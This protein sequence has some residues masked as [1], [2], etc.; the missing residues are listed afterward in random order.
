M[1]EKVCSFF[2][3]KIIP[4]DTRDLILAEA[5]KHFCEKG[6]EGASIR[7]ICEGAKVNVSA[8]K[9]H[10]G[11]KEGLYRE[12]FKIYGESRLSSASKI[13][14]KPNSFEELKLRIKLFC[15]DFIKE[16]LENMYTT[17]MICR[18]IETENPLIADIFQDTFLKVYTTLA[19]MFEDAKTKNLIRSDLDTMIITSAFFHNLTTTLRVDHVGEKYFNRTLRDPVYSELFINNI[20]TIFFDGIKIQE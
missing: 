16:G 5:R 1:V 8:I 4:A 14:T 17:K 6:F 13:L 7:D 12:C 15:E 10:F 20:I 19:E 3:K 18:E 2:G 11:G 9:Y